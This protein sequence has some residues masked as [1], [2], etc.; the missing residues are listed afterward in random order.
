[1]S[2]V[3]DLQEALDDA[4]WQPEAE[5]KHARM[6]V[7]VGCCLPAVR[8][9]AWAGDIIAQALPQHRGL[10]TEDSM[11]ALHQQKYSRARMNDIS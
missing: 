8:Q 10:L 1:M 5:A 6:G 2:C 3:S 9:L 11:P 7:S 4:H